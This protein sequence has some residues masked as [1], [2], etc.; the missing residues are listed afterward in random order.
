MAESM[1][2]VEKCRSK[3]ANC[4]GCGDME[5]PLTDIRVGNTVIA[6]CPTC[7]KKLWNLLSES[8]RFDRIMRGK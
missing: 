8:I 1:I 7:K 3:Y 4:N 5:K 2:E 6:L